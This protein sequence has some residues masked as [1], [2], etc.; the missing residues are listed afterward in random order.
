MDA[1]TCALAS[2]VLFVGFLLL[3][4]LPIH[5]TFDQVK[6]TTP[7]IVGADYGLFDYKTTEKNEPYTNFIMEED[8]RG[9]QL[10]QS[11]LSS[12]EQKS[13]VS[14]TLNKCVKCHELPS[15]N[16]Q[17]LLTISESWNKSAIVRRLKK[18]V[19]M[20]IKRCKRPCAYYANSSSSATFRPLIGDIVF[21]LNPG[22]IS[23]QGNT[24]PKEL[25]NITIKTNK[26]R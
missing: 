19:F 12:G 25:Q 17:K 22:P 7:G 16:L 2:S 6:G 21:K 1:A 8:T 3:I 26:Q 18:V 13:F 5:K 14:S 24:L 23:T 11:L 15:T 20:D 9:I 10:P 4:C